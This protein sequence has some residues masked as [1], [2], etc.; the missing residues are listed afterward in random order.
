MLLA[1]IAYRTFRPQEPLPFTEQSAM[2]AI[3]RN[4]KFQR[5]VAVVPFAWLN[6]YPSDWS[7]DGVSHQVKHG[8]MVLHFAGVNQK[9]SAIRDWL[10]TLAQERT[11][12]E[13]PLADTTLTAQAQ[14]FWETCK[15]RPGESLE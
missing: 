13:R 1:V 12:W 7:P 11:L 4:P 9:V 3:L 2:A 15:D 10:L 14:K 6:S 5:H 8:D